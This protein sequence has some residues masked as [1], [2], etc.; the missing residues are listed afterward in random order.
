[1]VVL[2]GVLKDFDVGMGEGENLIA[3]LKWMVISVISSLFR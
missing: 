2:V 3:S 1:M